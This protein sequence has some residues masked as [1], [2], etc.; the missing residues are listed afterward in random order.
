M[1]DVNGPFKLCTCST[2]VDRRKPHWILHR[3]ILS[4]EKLEMMGEFSTPN[5]YT[6]ISERSLQR[7]LNSVNVFDFDYEPKEGD[8]L[9]LFLN[10]EIEDDEDFYP[11][12]VVEFRK[13]K[14]RLLDTFESSRFTHKKTQSGEIIGPKSELTIAYEKFKL[15]ASEQQ[16]HEFQYFSNQYI[17]PTVQRTKKGLI[18]Y[19]KNIVPLMLI[20]VFF[21]ACDLQPIDY[22]KKRRK[23]SYVNAS[24]TQTGRLRKA[25]ARKS[26]S[27]SKR[28]FKNR[29]NSRG[30]YN[31]NKNRRKLRKGD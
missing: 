31:R 19:L 3:H 24:T 11:D 8:F 14:W 9:E 30:Y 21:F 5:P 23:S 12:Y 25:H 27:T 20:A 6:V 15:N 26:I 22:S 28:A 4:R 17:D 1:C 10:P 13:A 18:A 16:F 7:R 29:I 2:K